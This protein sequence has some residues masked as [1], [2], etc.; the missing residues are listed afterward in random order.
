MK[1]SIPERAAIGK[2]KGGR[3]S[4]LNVFFFRAGLEN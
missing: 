2:H 3:S 1:L 4:P